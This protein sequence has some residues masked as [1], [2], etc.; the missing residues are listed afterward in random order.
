MDTGFSSLPKA[1]DT[2]R[3]RG[4]MSFP[5]KLVRQRIKTRVSGTCARGI[6]R[7]NPKDSKAKSGGGGMVLD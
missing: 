6:V 3:A 2:A 1:E 5:P 7:F 4:M